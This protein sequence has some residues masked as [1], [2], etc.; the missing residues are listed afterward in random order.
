MKTIFLLIILLLSV[1][2]LNAQTPDLQQ[3]TD[4]GFATTNTCEFQSGIFCGDMI[5]GIGSVFNTGPP[6]FA[7][8]NGSG[9][10]TIVMQG[11]DGSLSLGNGIGAGVELK[12]TGNGNQSAYFIYKNAHD[13]VAYKSDLPTNLSQFTATIPLYAN[14]SIAGANGLTTGKIYKSL[15]GGDAFL[16]VKQ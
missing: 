4:Q 8:T 15:I 3:V 12:W 16:K 2:S 14:D 13:T 10:I 7:M 9:Q 1:V 5:T 11:N 6:N